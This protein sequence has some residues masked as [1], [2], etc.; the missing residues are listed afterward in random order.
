MAEEVRVP[1]ALPVQTNAGQAAG[2][3]QALSDAVAQSKDK[4]KDAATQ[5]RNLRGSTDEVKAAKD[6][7]KSVLDQEK[8]A[9]NDA[10]LKLLKHGTSAD[11]V[12]ADAKK[13]AKGES[14][15]AA[16]AKA[17]GDAMKKASED[18][19]KLGD[20]LKKNLSADSAQNL[21][22][23]KAAALGVA[24]ALIAVGV[25]AAAGLV[26]LAKWIFTSADAARSL[27]LVREAAAGTKADADALGMQI[28]I[29]AGKVATSKE[30]LTELGV[31]LRKANLGGQ[32]YVDT[33]NAVA[34]A[35][36]ALGDSAGS[37]IR[38]IIERGRLMGTMGI[39][40]LELQGTGLRFQEV[41]EALS[42]SMGV[43]VQKAT[44][45]LYSGRVKLADGAAAI[46]KAIE[47]RL[48]DINLRKM[49]SLENIGDT[50]KKQTAKLSSGVNIEPAIRAFKKL[51][52]MFDPD[53]S[54]TGGALKRIV[55]ALGNGMVGAIEKSIPFVEKLV[56]N[57][58]VGGLKAYIGWLKVKNAFKDT[59]KDSEA[60]K[61]F[62]AVNAA[63]KVMSFWL[64]SAE[65]L[66]RGLAVGV[67]TA[68]G[69][70]ALVA[71]AIDTG[72]IQP[73]RKG[74]DAIANIEW[75]KLGTS[76]VDGIV[77]GL[78]GSTKHLFDT[79]SG[80]GDVVKKAFTGK[81]E[82]KS[83]SRVGDRY[84]AAFD[85]GIEQGIDRNAPGVQRAAEDVAPA[86]PKGGA[87]AGGKLGSTSVVINMPI[88]YSGGGSKGGG[89]VDAGFLEQ[90]RASIRKVLLEELAA[91]GIAV[92]A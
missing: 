57:I 48:G 27:S 63:L 78:K 76:I 88:N 82:I 43:S 73:F 42:K 50:L 1:I 26:S 65:Y 9:L 66:L 40:P 56:R 84:G 10:T 23:I 2:D 46:R 81:L 59:F 37:K 69:A 15:A 70:I 32:T 14:D 92:P 64:T 62:D 34:Q 72:F 55:T 33:L 5:L 13:L 36:E 44:E 54:A 31:A 47:D 74:Y 4:I 91:A 22:L 11:K 75:A 6:Q 29:L 18:A 71:V 58:V 16:A 35:N 83:P 20:G 52:D 39:N 60:L 61:N 17:Q 7:L 80:L 41:A 86:M 8:S 25:A 30:K 49:F 77:N 53:S 12:A 85:K 89:D 79:V 51:F 68:I 3:V 67:V 90:L 45:A 19:K 87:L 21:D 28:D 38:E 24:S